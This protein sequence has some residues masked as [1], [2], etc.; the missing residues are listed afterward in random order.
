MKFSDLVK[1]PTEFFMRKRDA[2]E[3]VKKIISQALTTDTSLL[4][5]SS[6]ISLGTAKCRKAL[7]IAEDLVRPF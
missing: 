2:L 1:K 3:M 5:A 6:I 7:C 4:A